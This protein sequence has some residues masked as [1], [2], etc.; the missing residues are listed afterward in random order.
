MDDR[1]D[2]QLSP[3]KFSFPGRRWAHLCDAEAG[4]PLSDLQPF[5]D[6]MI[7]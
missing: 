5:T 3:I 6:T 1:Y 4:L 2:V 7:P